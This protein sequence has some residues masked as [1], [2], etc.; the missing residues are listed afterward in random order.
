MFYFRLEGFPSVTAVKFNGAMNLAVGTATG[1]ILLY[2]I[3]SNKPSF[4]KDHMYGLPIKHVEFH[5]QQ[6]L[7][8]SLD[9]SILKIWDK[10]DVND[11]R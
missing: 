7:I 3:R 5:H 1:Q 8:Y 11:S 10:N 2:D 4:V 6:D 9:S